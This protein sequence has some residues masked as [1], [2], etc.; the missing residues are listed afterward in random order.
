MRKK[1]NDR[2]H[3]IYEIVNTNNGKSYIGITA[4][5][6]RR[7][8][9]SARLRFQ[10]HQSRAR[11]ENKQCAQRLHHCAMLG[12]K[13]R[14]LSAFRVTGAMES[15]TCCGFSWVVLWIWRET[16]WNSIESSSVSSSV[17]PIT[18][19][20]AGL[21]LVSMV[22]NPPWDRDLDGNWNMRVSVSVS[23]SVL[24]GH[25][26]KICMYSTHPRRR[27]EG[28]SRSTLKFSVMFYVRFHNVKRLP[29]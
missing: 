26:S 14:N 24:F 1:R 9:Y 28:L 12:A 17:A 27:A 19:A 11:K 22:S 6:G 29:T 13:P 8:Q 20:S 3:V 16:P 25:V 10:K 2:N 7:F 5:I 15:R 18:I 21:V 23:V 4:A